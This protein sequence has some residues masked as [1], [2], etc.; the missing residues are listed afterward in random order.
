MASYRA[1]PGFLANVSPR[2]RTPVAASVIVGVLFIALTWVYLLTTSVHNAFS[3]AIAVTGLLFAI[4]YILTALATVVYYRRRVFSG[5]RDFLLLGL[6]PLGAA[7]FLGWM[8]T[9]TLQSASAPQ[10]WSLVGIVGLGLIMLL[11]A[12][13]VLRSGFFQMP[14][15][16][17]QEG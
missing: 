9:K 15:E 6:L 7:G 4:L 5:A 8:L 1:L 11:C 13:F 3:D 2:F 17:D 10:I 14:R 12:R 16:S